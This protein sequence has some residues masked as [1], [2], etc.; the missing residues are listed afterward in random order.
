[1]R[2]HQINTNTQT[3]KDP[4]KRKRQPYLLAAFLSVSFVT[5]QSTEYW[6]DKFKLVKKKPADSKRWSRKQI[7]CILALNVLH[8]MTWEQGHIVVVFFKKLLTKNSTLT[9]KTSCREGNSF[10]ISC[11]LTILQL[12]MHGHTHL[13][14][15]SFFLI[16]NLFFL[17]TYLKV[18]YCIIINGFSL[19]QTIV[20]TTKKHTETTFHSY[21]FLTR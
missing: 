15:I 10:N 7:I 9:L 5:L 12:A 16:S 3:R 18:L 20:A 4:L 8:W 6:S 1:M 19:E 21:F 11:R 17:L 13:L 2:L 14:M